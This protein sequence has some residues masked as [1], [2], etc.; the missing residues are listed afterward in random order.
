MQEATQVVDA[1]SDPASRQTSRSLSY[2]TESS[3]QSEAQS[4][5]AYHTSG[6][7]SSTPASSGL[8]A[9]SQDVG[10]LR[11]DS[12]ETCGT[13]AA[14]A[15]EVPA[16][17]QPYEVNDAD[18]PELSE[19]RGSIVLHSRPTEPHGT[20]WCARAPRSMPPQATGTEIWCG[21]RGGLSARQRAH[22][23]AF[24]VR[25]RDVIGGAA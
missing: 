8:W 10:S 7:A 12:R 5:S 4:D 19:L 11:L 2:E 24:R 25:V 3:S 18:L 9:G 16:W 14:P 21:S 15:A 13:A 23:S 6:G 1:P 20:S 22:A 17:M